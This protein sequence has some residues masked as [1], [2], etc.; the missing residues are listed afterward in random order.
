M[1]QDDRYESRKESVWQGNCANICSWR[2]EVLAAEAKK[3]GAASEVT[4][5]IRRIIIVLKFDTLMHYG[6]AE[7][8]ELLK[9]KTGAL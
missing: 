9:L 8:A 7:V 3:A 1:D 5:R 4:R 6:S 2:T